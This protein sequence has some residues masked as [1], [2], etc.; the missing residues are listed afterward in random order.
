MKRPSN[1]LFIV[2]I[3]SGFGALG[4]FVWF[5]YLSNVFVTPLGQSNFE[6]HSALLPNDWLTYRGDVWSVGYPK[7]YEATVRESDGAVWFSPIG[8]K[9]MKTYFLITSKKESLSA[10][11]IAQKAD[12]YPDPDE[13]T[14]ANYPAVK[15]SIGN[16][17]VEYYI[18]YHDHLIV[19]ASDDPEDETVAIMFATFAI[20][21]E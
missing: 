21:I 10:F 2:A 18:A 1:I 16:H 11:K 14:I 17:R 7:D 6:I 3:I 15:Y 4:V 19:V 20:N 13:V 12:G 9:E 5:G 8:T